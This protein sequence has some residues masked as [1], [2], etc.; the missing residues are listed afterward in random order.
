MDLIAR[1][2][3]NA[4]YAAILLQ[5]NESDSGTAVQALQ[6]GQTSCF[7]SNRLDSSLNCCSPCR[8]PSKT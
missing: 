7:S 4:P 1:L 8:K 5:T 2:R 3:R 6:N